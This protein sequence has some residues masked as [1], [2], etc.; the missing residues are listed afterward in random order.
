MVTVNDYIKK[1]NFVA[2]G[3]LD[4]QERIV[5]ANETK[6][7]RLNSEAFTAGIGSDGNLLNN[8][9][10]V[11]SGRYTVFTQ[12]LN[13]RK[14]AG[15]LYDFMETGDFL[16]NMQLQIQPSLTKFNI[17]STGT[18]GGD[19]SIFFSSYTNLF[20]LD[21]FNTDVLNYEI[22]YPPL[23]LYIKKYL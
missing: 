22:I 8:Q 18:G 17:F 2:A 7:V 3:M 10:P 9:S 20:G 21:P 12:M 6:I 23:M 14:V 16:S 11:F 19:K 13:P 1:C 5:L 4:E 15:S